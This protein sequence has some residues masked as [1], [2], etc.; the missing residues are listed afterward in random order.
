[1]M[2]CQNSALIKY[3]IN[4]KLRNTMRKIRAFSLLEMLI[5]LAT[6]GILSAIA[7]PAYTNYF[8]HQKRLAAK[9]SLFQLASA[10]ENYFNQHDSYQTANL[11]NL[12]FKAVIAEDH[13]L[14]KIIT[15]ADTFYTIA[16]EPINAQKND[17]VCGTLLLNS[18][19]EKSTEG[20]GNSGDC[21]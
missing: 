3:F 13:Y 17:T 7:Y 16:A 10:L 4:K 1:M 15:L 20:T 18:L 21:W 11:E 12:G 19:G 14:L 2:P 9:T 5:V 6:L 8:L